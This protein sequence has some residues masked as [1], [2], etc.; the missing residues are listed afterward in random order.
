MCVTLGSWIQHWA[1]FRQIT[2]DLPAC[3]ACVGLFDGQKPS[4]I[5]TET[6]TFSL[7]HSG[8]LGHCSTV[9][10]LSLGRLMSG[11]LGQRLLK[12]NSFLTI[13]WAFPRTKEVLDSSCAYRFWSDKSA[14]HNL[15]MMDTFRK[16]SVG[17]RFRKAL[18]SSAELEERAGKG[19]R[20]TQPL[21]AIQ[22]IHIFTTCFLLC[23]HTCQT[24]LSLVA[25][26]YNDIIRCWEDACV[27]LKYKRKLLCSNELSLQSK[28]LHFKQLQSFS[29]ALEAHCSPRRISSTC[30]RWEALLMDGRRDTAPSR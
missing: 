2:I 29:S 22:T 4:W 24:M 3:S 13:F 14:D 17:R 15:A 7:T 23:G 26:I 30:Y 18:N 11:C 27:L 28:H 25:R 9:G 10:Y 19:K 16:R 6:S 21:N 20:K 12:V 1:L 8:V 5:G